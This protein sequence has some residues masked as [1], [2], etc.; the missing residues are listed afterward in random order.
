[1][2][3]DVSSPSQDE[4]AL[5]DVSMPHH[6]PVSDGKMYADT[7]W[8]MPHQNPDVLS[9]EP[10]HSAPSCLASIIVPCYHVV[11][12]VLLRFSLQPRASLN[13]H[14]SAQNNHTSQPPPVCGTSPAYQPSPPIDYVHLGRPYP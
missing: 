11:P 13:G 4:V 6:P 8:Y 9:E 1:M 2:R 12:D 14:R 3:H 10:D 7:G 5:L